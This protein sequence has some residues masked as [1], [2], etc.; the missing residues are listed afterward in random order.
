LRA[1]VR[2]VPLFVLSF[3]V[4]SCTQ[5]IRQPAMDIGKKVIAPAEISV[6]KTPAK[7]LH[8]NKKDF[9]I[10]MKPIIESENSRILQVRQMLMRLKRTANLP[11]QANLWLHQLAG[12]YRIPVDGALDKMFWHQVLTRVDIVPI[13][14]AMAQAANESAWGNSRFAREANNY[15]G[16]WCFQK[17]CG[18]VPLRRNVGARHEVKRFD[19]PAASVRAYMKNMNTLH[20][21]NAFRSLRRSMRNQGKPLDS[22]LLV[23]G[24]K[25]YSERGADYVR[26]IRSIIRKNKQWMRER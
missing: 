13:E 24:L 22:E 9:F 5:E 21:Y 23:M 3:L 8:L 20:A 16:Q 6:S 7:L 12:E 19:S 10:L 18:L 17:G 4:I 25:K 14:M 15:F 26:I 1:L 11:K 2:I